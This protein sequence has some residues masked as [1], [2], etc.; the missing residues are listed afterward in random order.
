MRYPLAR[1]AAIGLLLATG[2]AVA[3]DPV[4]AQSVRLL[5][6]GAASDLPQPS[7]SEVA[8]LRGK[9]PPPPEA[10]AAA[11]E[12]T[13]WQTLAGERLWLVNLA[14]G[15][16]VA[17]RLRDTTQVGVRVVRCAD[18]HLPRRVGR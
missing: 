6:G 13:A 17:C 9:L 12:E 2:A 16:V 10:P 1:V 15:R 18:G 3:A 14:E 11:A 7:E 4:L 8:V 5:K